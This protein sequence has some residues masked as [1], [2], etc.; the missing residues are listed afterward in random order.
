MTLLAA[1]QPP[2]TSL[3]AR[4]A[5]D[6]RGAIAIIFALLVVILAGLVGG[7]VDFARQSHAT[8]IYRSTIDGAILAAAR[9]KQSGASDAE[10]IAMAHSFMASA[11]TKIQMPVDVTFNISS[12]GGTLTG[13][14]NLDI[15]STFLRVIG[16]SSL[17]VRVSTQARFGLGPDVEM[18][19][20]LDVTGSMRGAKIAALKDA[21]EELLDVFVPSEEDKGA[22]RRVAL[23]P[24]AASVKLSSNQ[25]EAATG[26]KRSGYK[27]CVVERMGP[28][29]YS[30]AEPSPGQFVIP[31]E[32][33]GSSSCDDGREIFPLSNKKSDLK[34]MIR[35]LNTSGGTAGHIGTAWA[36]YL[37]SPAWAALFD[38]DEQ[39][40]AYSALTETKPGG[41][42][43]LRKIA[44]LMT[45]GEY[46]VAYSGVD[47]TTQA[48]ALC[49]GMKAAGIEV[50]TVGFELGGSPTVIETLRGC[51]TSASHFYNAESDAALK[52]AFRDIATKGSMLRLSQ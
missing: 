52:A 27:G 34:K 13:R 11:K 50:F 31:L 38:T 5:D 39:P 14:A 2:G 35:S 18:S 8:A 7:A 23:A 43:K 46:N 51:A 1:D 16:I 25:F 9:L 24:F 48:R 49:V 22:R 10:A 32:S 15:P 44:V 45:D 37:L 28:Q 36:W 20:M 42:A 19:L 6:T 40:D 17:A 4:F 26:M 12:D 47:S 21:V 33:Y 3:S 29:A 30:N 41:G